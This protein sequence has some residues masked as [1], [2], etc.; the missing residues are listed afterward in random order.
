MLQVLGAF[1]VRLSQK[2]IPNP[3]IFAIILSMIVYIL[4]ITMTDTGPFKMV[5]YWYDG[6]WNLLTFGMQMVALLLFGYV[7]ATSPPI[8]RIVAWA[9]RFPRNG[10]QAILLICTL[11]MVFAYLN[12]GLGLIVG[13]IAAREVCKQAKQRGVK[14]HYPLAA[15]AGFAGLMIFAGGFSASAPLVMNTEGHF[16]FERY[17]LVPISET[18]LAPYNF[19]IV[20]TWMLIIPFVYRAMHPPMDEIEEIV[21]SDDEAGKSATAAE[22]TTASERSAGTV[23]AY[24][25]EAQSAESDGLGFAVIG[26]NEGATATAVPSNKLNDFNVAEKL[27]NA[28]FLTWIVAAAGI[29]YLLYHFATKGF[30]L[31]LNIVNFTLLIAGMLAYKTP[32]AYVQAVDEGVRSCG[33]LVLQFPFYAGILGMMASSGLVTLFAGWLISI[34]NAY[35]FPA[36]A[37]ISAAIVNLFVPS[38]GGQWAIQGPM[39]LEASEALGVDFGLTVMAFTYGDQLTNGIQPF[40]MLPLLGVTMLK[41]RE[42][43]G[44]TSVVMLVAFFIFALGLTFLPPFFL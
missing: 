11:A 39:L 44:Y 38:A 23:T 22:A 34:S 9:A 4:G 21:I 30:D 35:T 43:L 40:W 1:C 37:M 5:E 25:R 12:W 15:A 2:Y 41:A 24:H 28:P 31:N 13:A 42:I 14:V 20:L 26:M 27:E 32:I 36:A 17:G 10:G 16:L 6:F 8:R 18:I 19:I 33:Q 29:S 7:L 3:L